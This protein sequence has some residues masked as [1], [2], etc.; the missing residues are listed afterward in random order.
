MIMNKNILYVPYSSNDND[1]H[2]PILWEQYVFSADF[3]SVN[4]MCERLRGPKAKDTKPMA[5]IDIEYLEYLQ[6]LDGEL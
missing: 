5:V 3:D 1:D 2:G 6:S 4:A